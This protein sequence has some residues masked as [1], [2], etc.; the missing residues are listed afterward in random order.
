[1]ISVLIKGNIAEA[2]QALKAEGLEPIGQLKQITTDLA[3]PLV[4]TALPDSALDRIVAWY[5]RDYPPYPKGAVMLY[6]R[7]PLAELLD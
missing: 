7:T 5:L 1:M 3:S 2:T 4:R 6:S